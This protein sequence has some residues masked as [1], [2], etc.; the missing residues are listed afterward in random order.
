MGK[1]NHNNSQNKNIYKGIS[2]DITMK[3]GEGKMR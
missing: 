3:K 1:I 2:F